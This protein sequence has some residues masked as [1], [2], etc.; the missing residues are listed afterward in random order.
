MCLQCEVQTQSVKLIQLLNLN[1]YSRSCALF[2]LDSTLLIRCKHILQSI[3]ILPIHRSR[4][5]SS[6]SPYASQGSIPAVDVMYADGTTDTFTQQG[7]YPASVDTILERIQYKRTCLALRR[8][9]ENHTRYDE[10]LVSPALIL[11]GQS[12]CDA[13]PVFS[14][15]C[16][17]R[18]ML[19][20]YDWHL[21]LDLLNF[22]LFK[23]VRASWNVRQQTVYLNKKAEADMLFLSFSFHF[24]DW[25]CDMG[26]GSSCKCK[27]CTGDVIEMDEIKPWT[28]GILTDK[29]VTHGEN[30]WFKT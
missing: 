20:I 22:P 10:S 16:L 19:I 1:R 29:W 17:T 26:H 13:S 2:S 18:T 6:L 24:I 7:D 27:T 30:K 12:R 9:P 15:L 23:I 3:Y 21:L 25:C 14:S 11:H 28:K 4:C 5:F 8:S